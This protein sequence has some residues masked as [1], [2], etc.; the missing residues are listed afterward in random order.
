MMEN[1]S[2]VALW[3][4]IAALVALILHFFVLPA[5]LPEY[6]AWKNTVDH[7]I[8][9]ADD[10][11]NYDTLKKVEDTCRAMQ[12]SYQADKLTWQ[13]YRESDSEEKRSWA[14]QALLRANRT[15]ATYNTYILENSYV[16]ADNVPVDIMRELPYLGGE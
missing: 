13:Q 12:A 5:V 6:T 1:G 9:K 4:C 14:E 8:Q 3:M 16:W 2:K 10:A 11:T 15:A 7:A